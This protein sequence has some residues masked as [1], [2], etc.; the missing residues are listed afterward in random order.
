M[1]EKFNAAR[2]SKNS[3]ALEHFLLLAARKKRRIYRWL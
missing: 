2:Y 1:A 3:A